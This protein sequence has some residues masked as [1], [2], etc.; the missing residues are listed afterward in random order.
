MDI[1]FSSYVRARWPAHFA[2][3]GL[4]YGFAHCSNS[5]EMWSITT[6]TALKIAFVS[7]LALF[8]ICLQGVLF[9]KAKRFTHRKPRRRLFIFWMFFEP[10]RLPSRENQSCSPHRISPTHPKPSSVFSTRKLF[11]TRTVINIPFSLS[12]HYF[13][14]PTARGN[15]DLLQRKLSYRQY[16]NWMCP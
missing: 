14:L 9:T 13:V 6:D 1:I 7:V 16:Y 4:N 12:F 5:S 10:H 15:A 3:I 11:C 8:F 2:N